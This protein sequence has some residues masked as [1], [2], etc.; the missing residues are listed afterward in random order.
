MIRGGELRSRETYALVTILNCIDILLTNSNTIRVC[1]SRGFLTLSVVII[2]LAFASL[3]TDLHSLTL[4][5]LISTIRIMVWF[6]HS[7]L[8][9]QP[10]SMDR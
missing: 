5:T 9:N 10:S 4:S 7:H 6:N 1:L 8:N 2:P 3:P